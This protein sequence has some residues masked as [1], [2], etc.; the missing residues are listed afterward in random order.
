MVLPV[1]AA[2]GG[3]VPNWVTAG[4]TPALVV[5]LLLTGQL[6]WGKGV[7]KADVD[8]KAAQAKTE[9]R[10]EAAESRERALQ[11][12]FMDKVLPLQERQIGLMQQVQDYLRAQMTAKGTG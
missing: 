7:D 8:A 6:R 5:L 4:M 10:A 3:D 1:L 12:A 9:A 11:Q 2:G